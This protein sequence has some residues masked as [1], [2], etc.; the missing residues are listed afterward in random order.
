MS[1]VFDLH[2]LVKGS[3]KQTN[4]TTQLLKLI[5]KADESNR[6]KLRKGFPTAVKT[7]EHY[8][9]TGEIVDFGEQDN[10]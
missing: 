1:I 10:S 9:L 6:E 4:F 2:D 8:Q 3:G 5:L 7:V